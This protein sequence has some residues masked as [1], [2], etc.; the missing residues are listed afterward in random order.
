M[1]IW[2]KLIFDIV[3]YLLKK[4]LGEKIYQKVSTVAI[5]AATIVT[6][7]LVGLLVFFLMAFHGYKGG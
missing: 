4:V 5:I 1:N 7:G 6:I 2:E 3:R